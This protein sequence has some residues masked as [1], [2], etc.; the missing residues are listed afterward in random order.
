M[1]LA[2]LVF[3]FLAVLL[4][5]LAFW[6]LGGW[7]LSRLASESS[8]CGRWFDR[9][10]VGAA[11]SALL[12][13]G[14]GWSGLLRREVLIAI[15]LVLAAVSLREVRS[16]RWPRVRPRWSDAPLAIAA[17]LFSYF[18]LAAFLPPFR[19]DD[20]TYHLLLPDSYL[21]AG[22]IVA[23]P[24]LLY[25]NMPHLT[26]V[27]YCWPLAFAGLTAPAVLVVGF[28]AITLVRLW[29]EANSR[30]GRLA[31]GTIVLIVLSGR[32]VQ[33]HLGPA[34]IEPVV[35]AFF[36]AA[37]LLV[38]R[39]HERGRRTGEVV[40]LGTYL[41]FAAASK[42]TVWPL[43]A[44]VVLFAAATELSSS[45]CRRS[46]LRVAAG[47]GLMVFALLSPWLL[48]NYRITGN[49]IYPNAH[50]LLGGVEWSSVQSMQ[51]MRALAARAGGPDPSL[52]DRF[53]VVWRL[54]FGD[55][56]YNCPSFSI[57]L[58]A[59]LLLSLM[60]VG[61]RSGSLR[62][63]PVL[64]VIGLALWASGFTNGRYLVPWVPVMALAV[65]PLLALWRA[66]LWVGLALLVAT[67]AAGSL[68]LATQSPP[69][70]FRG[71]ELLR[72]PDPVLS[73]HPTW[74]LC[75]V[76]E[77]LMPP[78]GRL[79]ALWENRLLCL[80]RSAEVDGVYQ[81]PRGLARLREADDA[82]LY[83]QDLAGRGVTHVVIHAGHMRN[84]V[85]ERYPWTLTD[86]EIYPRWQFE[87]DTELLRDFVGEELELIQEVGPWGIFLLGRASR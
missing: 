41:G 35:G 46:A 31:A 6:T 9:I 11:G 50:S 61:H 39:W 57:V 17:L 29:Q 2:P 84:Y 45:R 14:M 74:Q 77:G 71:G 79:L 87:R 5:G 36:L 56:F 52:F 81:A 30:V 43:T 70:Y 12:A 53:A 65:V 67:V 15:T 20:L 72:S 3:P 10:V 40:L 22:R 42:Y 18:G 78:E 47:L 27:L 62:W 32:N 44:L 4:L 16:W 54:P 49:P 75:Q 24:D 63:L 83:A 55:N 68:Q 23:R 60:S 76:L 8:W 26:E 85:E 7:V 51:G 58:M 69:A 25:A 80:D 73:G 1:A 34:H 33:W 37:V 38:V 28:S 59:L 19:H 64:A 13:L 82:A 21:A 86:P 48:K 66:R